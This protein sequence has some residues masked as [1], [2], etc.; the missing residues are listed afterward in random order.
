[1]S[2]KA[3]VSFQNVNG[4]SKMHLFWSETTSAVPFYIPTIMSLVLAPAILFE[5]FALGL[6]GIPIWAAIVATFFLISRFGVASMKKRNV[7]RLDTLGKEL[8]QIALQSSLSKRAERER[9]DHTLAPKDRS[10]STG[11]STSSAPGGAEREQTPIEL[12]DNEFE[13]SR[14]SNRS[15]PD[16]ERS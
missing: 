3:H 16:R 13:A 4:G 11:L 10:E 9:T 12:P 14:D 6:E 7:R 8:T 2:K 5:E 1:M 15:N